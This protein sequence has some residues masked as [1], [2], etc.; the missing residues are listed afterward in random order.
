MQFCVSLAIKLQGLIPFRTSFVVVGFLFNSA[1]VL[2]ILLLMKNHIKMVKTATKTQN[3][4]SACLS[5]NSE[6]DTRNLPV[7]LTHNLGC[8]GRPV[9][10]ANQWLISVSIHTASRP[11]F[12]S[13]W[14]SKQEAWDNKADRLGQAAPGKRSPVSLYRRIIHP[15]HSVLARTGLYGQQWFLL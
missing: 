6:T 12:S 4:C 8:Q 7:M 15:Y 14:V 5:W 11:S 9:S 13:R 2:H 1:D 3:K 10:M